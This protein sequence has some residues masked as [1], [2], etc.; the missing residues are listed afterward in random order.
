VTLES[1][2][3]LAPNHNGDEGSRERL[4]GRITALLWAVVVAL[5]VTFFYF[6]SSLCITILLAAFLAVLVEPI[7]G[8]LE[9]LRLPRTAAAAL[10]VVFGMVLTGATLYAFYDKTTA[11]LDTLPE[12]T[13]KIRKAIE[14]I[15]KQIQLVQE[16]AGRL[17][18][19]PP[20]K[21]V[22]EVR[23][24][25]TPSWP[26][27]LARGVGSV[28]GAIVIAGVVPFLIF[29]MLIRKDH[30]YDWLAN[31]FASTTDVP[32]FVGR[33]SRMVR[34][35]AGG[36]LVVGSIMAAITTLVLVGL[37][38]DGALA[39]GT[40]SGFLNL[41]PFL[42]VVLA[43]I[44]PI[45]A[46]TLQFSTAGPFAIIAL[47]VVFLH[48]LSANLLVPKFIGSRVNIGP[49]AATIGMLFWSWV[50]G[51]IGLLLAVPLTAF[52]KLVADCHPALLPISNL[53]AE[54][55][56]ALPRWAQASQD[57]VTRAIPFLRDRFR[58][59]QKQ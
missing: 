23:V 35:F 42:G 25:D 30:I 48:L 4:L 57:T 56:R 15:T 10:V 21:K 19:A 31:T 7:V 20:A 49:V 41:I 33:A 46:A 13:A 11:F 16:N 8:L 37:R 40:A 6:A 26:A 14:P 44:V 59:R 34:G 50:W 36:N 18:P 1:S 22:P 29:F 55:P 52:V 32:V 27:Y 47:T 24:T 43:L 53:L 2:A 17:N 45:L 5:A 28:G 51:A 54:R 39:L 38:M 9:K 12:Y 3:G 58:V